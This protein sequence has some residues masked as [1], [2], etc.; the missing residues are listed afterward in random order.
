MAGQKDE[1]QQ[2]QI[3]RVAPRLL[4][5]ALDDRIPYT[6]CR[7]SAT[8]GGTSVPSDLAAVGAGP[9]LGAGSTVVAK[10][11]GRYRRSSASG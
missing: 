5:P 4:A 11:D 1:L 10:D 9:A 2:D 7:I 3:W 6:N 8:N